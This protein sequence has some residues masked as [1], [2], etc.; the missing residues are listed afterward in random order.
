MLT[1]YFL[2][3]VFLFIFIHRSLKY[4][5]LFKPPIDYFRDFQW[6][7]ITNDATIEK[8]ANI[9]LFHLFND[10]SSEQVTRI[11]ILIGCSDRQ[12]LYRAKIPRRINFML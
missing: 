3:N 12:A 9:L 4:I 10:D 7:S 1:L 2:L 8:S 6:F 5:F 11:E